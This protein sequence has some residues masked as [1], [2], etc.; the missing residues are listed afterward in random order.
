MQRTAVSKCYRLLLLRHVRASFAT[1]LSVSILLS[2]CRFPHTQRP[3]V[4]DKPY[5]RYVGRIAA[6]IVQQTS[7]P[8]TSLPG[9]DIAANTPEPRTLLTAL[10]EEDD[11]KYWN[12]T[13]QEAI[14]YGLNNSRVLNDLGGTVLRYPDAVPTNMMA[15]IVQSD[16]RFGI[17]GALSAYDTRFNVSSRYENNN[18][19]LNNLFLSGGNQGR[20]FTQELETAQAELVKQTMTGGQVAVRNVTIYDKNSMPSNLFPSSWTTWYEAE[21]RQSLLKGGGLQFN[22]IAGPNSLPGYYN[23]VKIARLRSDISQADFEIALRDFLSNIENAYWDLHFAYR[24][25]AAKVELRDL[26]LEVYGLYKNRIDNQQNEEP[27]RLAQLREQYYRL[28]EDVQNALTGRRIDGT[29]T[30]NGTVPGT[31][32]GVSGVY[33]AER[34]LRLLM[35]VPT[36]DERL[37]R[38]TDEAS[39][40][41]LVL[42]WE[43][44][45][46][47]AL[48]RRPELQRQKFLI[49]K[50]EMELVASQ[51]LLKPQ[52]DIVAKY[53]IR[54]FGEN[55]FGPGDTGSSNPSQR[56]QTAYSD[57]LTAQFQESAV[58]VE[59]SMPIGFRQAHAAVA[60][61]Q[62]RVARERA[63][64][65]EQERQIIHDVGNAVADVMRSY[66]VVKSSWERRA[67]AAEYLEG[68]TDKIRHRDFGTIQLEQ[69]LDAQRRFS[70]ADAHYYLSLSDHQIALKNVNYEKG[71]LLDY[72]N[73][74]PVDGLASTTS[75][76]REKS[77]PELPD[78]LQVADF[79]PERLRKA[80]QRRNDQ[81]DVIP[82][83]HETEDESSE[84][85]E[86]IDPKAPAKPKFADDES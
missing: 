5:Q 27:F 59:Y 10:P 54:G 57:L 18:Q 8:D 61:A 3:I 42:N 67:A 21:A 29:R 47:E 16:P 38:P 28:K 34:R 71:S 43:G 12:L 4:D 44:V 53:R 48:S 26:A 50:A 25:L 85:D 35:G 19:A 6:D 24:D 77:L 65:F 15:A 86:F 58:G 37:I 73:I 62:F 41:E 81:S 70:E 69:W 68:L 22:Q 7:A 46:S 32:R 75:E 51:N 40:A 64:L 33:L 45:K 84:P 36:S 9:S 60:Q 76:E 30:N 56:F 2:G 66:A 1:C 14:H 78:D 23:G 74:M 79:S 49:K 39:T 83:S 72:C 82:T 80:T 20:T 52:L 11:A 55:L 63:V 31:F 13:L 17:E